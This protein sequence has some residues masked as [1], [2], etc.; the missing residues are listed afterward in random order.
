VSTSRQHSSV[1]GIVGGA[2]LVGIGG[3][4][5]G[6]Q[7][8]LNGSISGT[9]WVAFAI[10]AL[11]AVGAALVR[12]RGD[13]SRVRAGE[14]QL[15]RSAAADV[16]LPRDTP[17]IV[18]VITSFLAL[19]FL[20]S[21]VLVPGGPWL[22]F[23]IF[24]LGAVIVVR[25]NRADSGRWLS[26]GMLMMLAGMLLFRLWIAYQGG[27]N[28]WALVSIDVPVLSWL[29]FGFLDPVKRLSLGSFTPDEFGFPPAGLSFAPTLA[30]WS[31]G[32]VLCV[33]GLVWAQ[34]SAREHE[35]DRIHALIRTLPSGLAN[36]VERIL[37]EDEWH[38]L[39]LH[40]LPERRLARRIESIVAERMARQ[41][42]LQAALE[43]GKFLAQTNSG[44]FAGEIYRS[45]VDASSTR[46]SSDGGLHAGSHSGSHGGPHAADA[47]SKGASDESRATNDAG[48][49]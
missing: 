26:N 43:S 37:P 30:A 32:F 39:G 49:T 27:R 9:G 33:A 13:A 29:P 28:Q 10:G 21:G 15:E 20:L 18:A 17:G 4:L 40:G 1:T 25:R 23:E 8:D 6:L 35:N 7:V 24:V 14:G 46:T 5:L 44:G 45:I 47:E 22:F 3:L 11:M 2:W 19:A 36:F 48:R 38:A 12:L 16:A 42:E 34:T 41:K 31:I